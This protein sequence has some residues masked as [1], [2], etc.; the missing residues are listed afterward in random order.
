[1]QQLT[2]TIQDKEG[3][4]LATQ[5]AADRLTLCY[6]APYQEGDTLVL[7][8]AE[9]NCYLMLQLDDVLGENFVYQKTNELVYHIPFG[10]KRISYNPKAFSGELHVL[11]VRMATEAEVATRKNLAKNVY[12]QHGDPG[13]FPHAH[14]NVE[15]RGEA[16]FAARNA[17]DG[18][19][20]NEGHGPWPFESW[21]INMQDDAEITL[22]FGRTVA[23]DA[24][25]LV[26]RADFP[27]DNYWQEVT[28]T[29]SDGT[30]LVQPLEK[31]V[32]PH[33]I[34]LDETRH[35]SWIRLGNL[36]KD[37]NDP[38]P[39]PALSHWEVYGK[40]E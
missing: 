24:M 8:V 33:E 23:V 30:T 25:A 28:F 15:T 31:S 27:H 36:K 9:A 38:S 21:G 1:M 29:F 2:L 4:V 7:S 18:N 3:R 26:T 20:C 16:V 10:E 13:C 35:V 5:S 34:V 14:A 32:A 11:T 40:E 17:I 12:D 22:E 6:L 37:P 39:F 19:S